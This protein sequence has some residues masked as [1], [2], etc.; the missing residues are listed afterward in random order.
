MLF[1]KARK[2]ERRVHNR[3]KTLRI[4]AIYF[5]SRRSAMDCVILDFS[6]SGARIR[7]ADALTCPNEFLLYC[8]D[9]GQVSCEVLWRRA[10]LIGVRIV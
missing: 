10:G 5:A 2:L 7:P 8:K 3:R 1:V 9:F 6:E 4:G